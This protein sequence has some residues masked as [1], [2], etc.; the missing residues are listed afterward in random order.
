MNG[1]VVSILGMLMLSMILTFII[2]VDCVCVE[3][4]GKVEEFV[5]GVYARECVQLVR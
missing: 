1:I 3:E 2:K 5:G 4:G